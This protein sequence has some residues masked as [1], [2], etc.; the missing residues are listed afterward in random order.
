MAEL[1]ALYLFATGATK[2]DIFDALA[3]PDAPRCFIL[4]DELKNADVFVVSSDKM[5]ELMDS[6]VGFRK[7]VASECLIPLLGPEHKTMQYNTVISCCCFMM[8]L[9]DLSAAA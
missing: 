1:K 6:D 7:V 4:V 3:N 2:R 8:A 5:A 9:L